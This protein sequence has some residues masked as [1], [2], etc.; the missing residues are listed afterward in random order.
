M[1]VKKTYRINLRNYGSPP[2][3]MVSQYDEGYAIAFEIFDGPL[4]VL[5]S[6]LSGYTFKLKGR[7]PGNPPF[8]A[9]EFEGTLAT[10]LNAVVSFEIDT[11]MTGRAGKGTAELVILDE[12][13]D[14]KFA[15]VNFAVYTEPAAVPDGSIDADVQRAMEIAEEVQ[16]IVDTAAAEVK[17][18][19]E[20]WAVGQR[21]GVDVPSTDPAYENNAKYYAGQ[22]QDIADSIG[23]DATLSVAGKAADAKKTG[24]EISELKED[25]SD[26]ETSIG[27]LSGLTTS[28]KGNLVA[29][30]NEAAQTGGSGG[31]VEIALP[32]MYITGDISEMTAE[33]N[34]V[35]KY[36][37]V[38]VDPDGKQ[39]FGYCSMKWQGESSMAYPKKNYTIKFF[40][41]APHRRKEAVDLLPLG[42]IKNKF[43]VKANWIDRSQARN[44]VSCR[45]WGR[46]VKSRHTAPPELLAS[47][48]NFG[49]INGYP[50]KV[51]VNGTFHGL[52]S[53]NLPKDEDLFGMDADNPL[54]CVVCGDNNQNTESN[55]SAFRSTTLGNSWELEVPDSWQTY[56]VEEDGQTVTH[57]VKDN[58]SSTI[59][60]VIDSTDEEFVA[61]I[62]DHIDLESAIDY[63]LLLFMECGVDSAARNL[64]LFTYDGGN[65]W[66]CSAYDKD[67]TWGNGVGGAPTYNSQLP[68]PAGY[69]NN[70]SLLWQRL[71]AL[72]GDAIWDRWNELKNTILSPTSIKAEF[73][74]FWQDI[75]D[76]DY[77]ADV[78]AWPTMPQ[79]T[80]DFKMRMRNFIDA[81]WTYMDGQIN[82]LRT[83][84]ACTGITLSE[85]SLSFTSGDPVTLTATVEPADTTD[86]VVWTSSNSS[87]VAVNNGVVTPIGEGN[88]IIT[89]T[90]GS[91]TATCSVSVSSLYFTVTLVGTGATLTPTTNINPNAPYTGTLAADTGYTIDSVAVTMGGV[92]I[93]STAYSDGSIS[94]ASVTGN[95]VVT[96]ATNVYIDPTGLVY[97]L[98]SILAFD[99][100]V[101][102]DTGYKYDTT[103][104][105]SVFIDAENP[106]DMSTVQYLFGQNTGTVQRFAWTATNRSLNRCLNN[107]S[108]GGGGIAATPG[109]RFKCVFRYDITRQ[110]QS[111][112]SSVDGIEKTNSYCKNAAAVNSTEAWGNNLHLGGVNHNGTL[113][114]PMLSG[115]LYQFRIYER[116][117]TDAETAALLGLS[118]LSTTPFIDDLDSTS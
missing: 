16:E 41:D 67:M 37:Y 68:C 32:K 58:L 92:D 104:S 6:S 71:T 112:R 11:T 22:A 2:A 77:A 51:Y 94:I 21:D 33:K 57:A 31:S 9:Y 101:D 114:Y 50:I 81:R 106:Q 82:A 26:V 46:M 55:A 48:P 83:P 56:D 19:A 100:T 113:E 115:K 98:P 103:K 72:F 88:A 111:N 14:V 69:I 1:A 117:L 89:A 12:E 62:N 13:N 27:D 38:F 40:Y 78:T 34:E 49:A 110:I 107:G 29:A 66:Y 96:V 23:I 64:I 47:S 79:S 5:A 15:S 60:F 8:L 93:T 54:H 102:V 53:F 10:A 36:S 85:S 87:V 59:A 65:K 3:V 118:S 116:R 45:L 28:E 18:E 105:L 52:Y 43:V 25:L 24:D 4:P 91:Q 86:S 108:L 35:K 80:I 99:G 61:D 109:F 73:D 97:S 44:V 42:I 7:Q 63:F 95:I 30:I 90:C 20:A 76:A 17:G 39:H 74:Y 75:T 84:V 70:N